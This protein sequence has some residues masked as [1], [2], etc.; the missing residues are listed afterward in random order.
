[1]PKTEKVERLAE[2]M[3]I[4]DFML[5]AEEMKAISALNKN[6]RYLDPG[7]YCEAY[8]NTFVPIFD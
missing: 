1:M 3:N 8:F 2:N 5:T 4:F 6:E 7:H